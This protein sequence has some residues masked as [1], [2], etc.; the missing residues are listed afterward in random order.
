[1]LD[2]II[3]PA[4]QENYKKVDERV[5]YLNIMVQELLEL[6]QL[7]ACQLKIKTCSVKLLIK[8]LSDKY[9]FDDKPKCSV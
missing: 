5:N 8:T 2:G 7:Q 1:M 3:K 9:S 4:E 6:S